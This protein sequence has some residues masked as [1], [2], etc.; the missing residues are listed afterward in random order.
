M[1]TFL[2][3]TESQKEMKR[4]TPFFDKPVKYKNVMHTL[5]KIPFSF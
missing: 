5:I 1:K 2:L 4:F 3:K